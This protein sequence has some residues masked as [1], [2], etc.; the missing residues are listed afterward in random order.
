MISF[1]V[2]GDAVPFARAGSKGTMRF[3][4]PK[5][6]SYEGAIKTFASAAMGNEPP[7]KG[8]VALTMRAEY[9]IPKSWSKKR[10]DAAVWKVSAPDLDNLAKIFKDAMSGIVYEDDAQ[11][12]WMTLQKKYSVFSRVTVSVMELL[13]WGE[14]Q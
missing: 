2:P 7:F 4:P 12:A 5:Q 13:H 3:T 1:V 8:P 14:T 9:L 11:V 10:R 6:R